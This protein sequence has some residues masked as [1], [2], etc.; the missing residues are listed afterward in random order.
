MKIYIEQACSKMA[1]RD[2]C[3][4]DAYHA[5]LQDYISSVD[6]EDFEKFLGEKSKS[7]NQ[8]IQDHLDIFKRLKDK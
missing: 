5:E 4:R 8:Q 3:F 2:L 1:S 6:S 7:L